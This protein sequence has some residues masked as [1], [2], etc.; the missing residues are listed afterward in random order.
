MDP[1]HGSTQPVD[2]SGPYSTKLSRLRRRCDL[3]FFS[4]TQN[5]RRRQSYSLNT[6]RPTV[7]L[8]LPTRR[9]CRVAD[10]RCELGISVIRSVVECRSFVRAL[11]GR[12]VVVIRRYKRCWTVTAAMR[13]VAECALVRRPSAASQLDI[14]HTIGLHKSFVA[15]CRRRRHSTCE[16]SRHV[17]D[18]FAPPGHLPP[19]NHYH[20]IE[21]T[22]ARLLAVAN[23]S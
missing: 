19:E 15:P 21:Q 3:D 12:S 10:R 18:D 17:Y 6:S 16:P 1:T 2:N 8:A 22:E 23:L 4:T 20:C 7:E 14:S 9:F 13:A 11:M 5:C